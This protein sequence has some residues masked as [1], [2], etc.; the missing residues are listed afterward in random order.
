VSFLSRLFSKRQRATPKVN[1]TIRHPAT[2]PDTESAHGSPREA[3]ADWRASEGH[4]QL[5]L[6][7][8]L[9]NA[10]EN[11]PKWVGWGGLLGESLDSAIQRLKTDGALL[12]VDDGKWRILYNRGAN[13]LKKMCRERGLKVSGTKEQMAERLASVD[14]SGLVLG[15]P[16]ELLRC[17]HEAEQIAN[18]RRE[19]WKQSQLATESAV[20]A[21]LREGKVEDALRICSAFEQERTPF[22]P[23]MPLVPCSRDQIMTALTATPP[24]LRSYPAAE[25]REARIQ[26]AMVLLG[27]KRVPRFT[28]EM[29][30]VHTLIAYVALHRSLGSWRESGVVVGVVVQCSND[31]PCR[32]CKKLEGRVWPIEAV[33]ELPN[34]AC[35]TPGGCR[36]ASVARLAD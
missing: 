3:Q 4:Q 22:H 8:T 10:A 23:E 15:Y 26:A 9:P 12:S 19:A 6:T 31:G 28:P 5:L 35:T 16:G 27:A 30:P 36:C 14:P 24:A 2:P 17:S 7:F 25:I 29:K 13:E 21:A 11:V 32:E 20:E 33:P 18:A 34:P 1:E